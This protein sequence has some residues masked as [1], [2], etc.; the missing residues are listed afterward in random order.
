MIDLKPGLAL[1]QILIRQ[2]LA[3]HTAPFLTP[4]RLVDD[5]RQ[6]KQDLETGITSLS[7]DDLTACILFCRW[8]KGSEETLT[9]ADC[10]SVLF[11]AAVAQYVDEF[12][13]TFSGFPDLKKHLLEVLPEFDLVW[14]TVHSIAT[15]WNQLVIAQL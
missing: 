15:R 9:K 7:C 1:A 14:E 3:E 11:A 5:L 8:L 4:S 13:M 2:S 6:V 10:V 12:A